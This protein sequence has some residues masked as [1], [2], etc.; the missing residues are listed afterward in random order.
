MPIIEL[1]HVQV[2]HVFFAVVE[3]DPPLWIAQEEESLLS[4]VADGVEYGWA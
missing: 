2:L 3:V 4:M 1:N